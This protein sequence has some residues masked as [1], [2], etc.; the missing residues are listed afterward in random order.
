MELSFAQVFEGIAISFNTIIMWVVSIA[1]LRR[2]QETKYLPALLVASGF[3]VLGFIFAPITLFSVIAIQLRPDLEMTAAW[4]RIIEILHNNAFIIGLFL[5][6]VFTRQVFRP[7]QRSSLFLLILI[8]ILLFGSKD[9]ILIFEAKG[10]VVQWNARF[11]VRLMY[12]IGNSLNFGWLAYESLS[13]WRAYRKQLKG[14]KELNLLVINRFLL[15]GLAGLSYAISSLVT[16][17]NV[18]YAMVQPLFP[19]ITKAIFILAFAIFSYLSWSPPGWFKQIINKGKP[20]Q[21]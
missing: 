2:Y 17:L 21:A 5:F 14:G 15:W 7:G 4:A 9:L 20:A 16:I 6:A 10:G 18:P 8:G 3:L 1:I 13:R 12:A 11:E 19:S